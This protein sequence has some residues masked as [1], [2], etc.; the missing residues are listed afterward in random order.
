MKQEWP[1]ARVDAG[2][3]QHWPVTAQDDRRKLADSH[4]ALTRCCRGQTIYDEGAPVECWYRLVSGT[5]RRFVVRSDG[6]RQI[7]DLLLAGD[8]FGF[9]ARGNHAFTAEAIIDGS[10]VAR[11]PR[12]RL[13]A[14]TRSDTRIA[15]EVQEMA[16][17]ETRRLQDLILI[18]GRTTAKEKVGAFLLHL[19]ERLAG[20]PA[21]RMILPLSRYDIADY[22][23]LSVETV[24]RALTA[25][26]RN[27][28]ITFTGTRQVE[29][30]DRR[31]I[32][33]SDRCGQMGDASRAKRDRM[34][35]AEARMCASADFGAPRIARRGGR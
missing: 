16:L 2:V 18:L 29:I 26:K 10:L 30:L 8:V 7:I 35:A 14:L 3:W 13:E 31:A 5:A 17:E 28:I 33:T 23:A 9:G 4:A 22:L 27:R 12:F 15:Q 19:G 32:E 24:S 25:L 34:S 20:R 21:D 11:Y 6:K 1:A